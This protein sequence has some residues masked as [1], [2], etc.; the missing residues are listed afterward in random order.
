MREAG[1]GGGGG[2][3][4]VRTG[5]DGALFD[6]LDIRGALA[7]SLVRGMDWLGWGWLGTLTPGTHAHAHDGLFG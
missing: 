4:A 1:K 7:V 2:E 5:G 3:Q 6:L